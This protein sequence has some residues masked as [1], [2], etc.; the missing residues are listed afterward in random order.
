MTLDATAMEAVN[1]LQK[2]RPGGPWVL[3][4]IEPDGRT[5]TITAQD[6][7]AVCVFV[8]ANDGRR[9]LY[10]SVNPT[11]SVMTSKAA[12]KDI[13]AAEY[14]FADLDPRDDEPSD[15]AKARAIWCG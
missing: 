7:G 11:K 5:E 3:T 14:L 12:K 2:L 15:V 9:N 1:F 8:H 4:A 6:A 13:L 10:Y